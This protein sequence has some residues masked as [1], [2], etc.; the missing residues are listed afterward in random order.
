MRVIEI[1]HIFYGASLQR[2]PL[3]TEAQYLLARY[4]FETLKFRRYEWKCNALNAASCRAA[5]R[6]GFTYEGVFRS[7]MIAKDRNRES[8]DAE[9]GAHLGMHAEQG[10]DQHPGKSGERG[11]E[12]K[13]ERDRDPHVDTHQARRILVLD[14]GEQR[15][16][17]A[18]AVKRELQ[19]NGDTDAH[20]GNDELQRKD[21][22]AEQVD[23]LLREKRRERA[24]FL[25]ERE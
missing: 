11:R 17:M 9:Q 3:A 15:L 16:P 2:T 19:S 5:E 13:R 10:G 25:A 21:A 18:G 1:G 20:N 6:F 12:R 23:R 7:H 22:G 8:L 14:D 4:A 24:R